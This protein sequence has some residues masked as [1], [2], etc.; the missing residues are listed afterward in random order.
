MPYFV[1]RVARANNNVWV[2]DLASDTAVTRWLDANGLTLHEAARI[3]LPYMRPQT[4]AQVARNV[5]YGIAAPI[6]LV[7]SATVSI[8][9]AVGNADGHSR[10][11]N[12]T[13][14]I[15]DATAVGA[16]ALLVQTPDFRDTY[17]PVG[18]TTNGVGALSMA[19]SAHAFRRHGQIV[20]AKREA[21]ERRSIAAEAA[22]S[23]IVSTN[24]AADVG[25][26]VRF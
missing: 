10:I 22:I 9:N 15:S 8:W 24:G 26:T 2:N 7:T 19:M 23:P 25:V 4:N 1:D 14:V 5:A 18:L 20:T 16:G 13:G 11:L 6:S 12:W 21:A 3:Q 17:R